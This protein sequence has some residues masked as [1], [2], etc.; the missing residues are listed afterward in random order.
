MLCDSGDI[1]LFIIAEN[2]LIDLFFG[3]DLTVIS[4]K[5]QTDFI[6]AFRKGEF[7]VC[8][9]DFFFYQLEA[10]AADG[11][12]FRLFALFPSYMSVYPGAQFYNGARFSDI[13]VAAHRKT[14]LHILF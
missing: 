8:R 4:G 13:V 3:V 11:K 7:L 10:D 1:A 14:K 2:I 12:A 9:P 6:F 5:Q